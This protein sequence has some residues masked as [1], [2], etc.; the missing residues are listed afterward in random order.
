MTL[1]VFFSDQA[2]TETRSIVQGKNFILPYLLQE[3]VMTTNFDES[4]EG[5]YEKNGYPFQTA[6]LPRHP[7]LLK[8]LIRQGG[9]RVLFKLHSTLNGELGAD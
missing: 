4:L 7:G 5:S 2:G 6:F 1:L 9:P 3:L 8:Q